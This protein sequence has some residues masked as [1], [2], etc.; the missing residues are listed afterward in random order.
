[1]RV[2]KRSKVQ[3]YLDILDA[4]KLESAKYKKASPTR[5][6]H[7]ANLAYD[8]FQKILDHLIAL[9][10]VCQVGDGLMLTEKGTK[11]LEEMQKNNDFLRRMGLFA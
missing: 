5:V 8:R 1:M 10:M 3:I 2:Y 4:V 7:L 11:C 9:G 6:S